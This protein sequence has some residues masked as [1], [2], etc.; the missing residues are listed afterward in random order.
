MDPRLPLSIPTEQLRNEVDLFLVSDTFQSLTLNKLR[1]FRELELELDS[2]GLVFRCF[3]CAPD[4]E[5]SIRQFFDEMRL[6]NSQHRKQQLQ[7]LNR[8]LA[9]TAFLFLSRKVS[10][11]DQR[12]EFLTLRAYKGVRLTEH[13]AVICKEHSRIMQSID[14]EDQFRL[15]Q[16]ITAISSPLKDFVQLGTYHCWGFSKKYYNDSFALESSKVSFCQRLSQSRHLESREMEPLKVQ[17]RTRFFQRE[18]ELEE[19]RVALPPQ[20]QVR[21]YE[22]NPKIVH[23]LLQ[24]PLLFL[25]KSDEVDRK[26]SLLQSSGLVAESDCRV[27]TDFSGQVY[28]F[29]EDGRLR[30]RLL[31]PEFFN[32][33]N[34]NRELMSK[35][36]EMAEERRSSS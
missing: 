1:V 22:K 21:G 32:S 15:N 17:E 23:Q 30:R 6:P 34:C 19:S 8:D 4:C 33:R 29:P 25:W 12:V 16:T 3:E 10:S 35:F 24:C 14:L 20:I 5:E 11:E 7:A 18:G 28:V 2:P 26:Q 27:F 36:L 13:N 9:S 31:R